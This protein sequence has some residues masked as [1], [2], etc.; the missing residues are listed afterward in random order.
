ME[1]AAT[2]TFRA[3]KTQ[4]EQMLADA[5]TRKA[6]VALRISKLETELSRWKGTVRALHNEA[7]QA[8]FS[9]TAKP[10]FRLPLLPAN[11]RRKRI[12]AAQLNYATSMENEAEAQR[13]YDA[14]RPALRT[15]SK[16]LTK[17]INGLKAALGELQIALGEAVRARVGR[18]GNASHRALSRSPLLSRRQSWSMLSRSAR[19]DDQSVEDA[20]RRLHGDAAADDAVFQIR[21]RLDDRPVPEDAVSDG[22]PCLDTRPLANDGVVGDI[23]LDNRARAD[24]GRVYLNRAVGSSTRTLPSIQSRCALR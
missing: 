9:L 21:A 6:R 4:V 24:D 18:G 19:F 11:E 14:E 22:R 17:T 3:A 15:E 12:E 23:A 8:G 5:T 13:L 7:K 16:K 2:D 10:G 1:N 20:V